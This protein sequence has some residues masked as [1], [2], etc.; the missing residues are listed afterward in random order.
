MKLTHSAQV[1]APAD[2]VWAIVSDVPRTARLVP[3]A[4]PVEPLGPDRYRGTVR[5]QVGP[6][7]LELAGEVEVVSLD[8]GTRTATLRF[9]ASDRALGGAVRAQARLAVADVAS[10]GSEVLVETDAQVLGR[11]G[12]LGEP[13]IRRK[14]DRIVSDLVADIAREAQA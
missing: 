13:I 4:G 14:A 10:G 3:G 7:R 5:V 9:D 11:I 1:A 6:V 2:R 8:E 12:E